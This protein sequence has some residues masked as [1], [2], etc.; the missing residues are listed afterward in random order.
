MTKKGLAICLGGLVT[1]IGYCVY[2]ILFPGLT[3]L[4]IP[5]NVLIGLCFIFAGVLV[6]IY[7]GKSNERRGEMNWFG[8]R[9]L[10]VLSVTVSFVCKCG[11]TAA[12]VVNDPNSSFSIVSKERRFDEIEHGCI[13]TRVWCTGCGKSYMLTLKEW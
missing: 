12:Y 3:G 1:W 13:D 11:A 6:S 5:A 4:G 7:E 8:K 10:K 9:G 2:L